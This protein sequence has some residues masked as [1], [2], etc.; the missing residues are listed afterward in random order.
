MFLKDEAGGSSPVTTGVDGPLEPRAPLDN[1]NAKHLIG[2]VFEC[3]SCNF[4]GYHPQDQQRTL[5]PSKWT[6]KMIWVEPV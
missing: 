1:G 5:D 3:G 4:V 6:R 2:R